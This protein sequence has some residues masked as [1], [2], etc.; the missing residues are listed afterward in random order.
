M[1]IR[2]NYFSRIVNNN[3]YFAGEVRASPP[4]RGYEKATELFIARLPSG[5]SVVGVGSGDGRHLTPFVKGG[6][7]V[8][9]IDPSPD[10]RAIALSRGVPTI[11]GTFENL[12]SLRL[13]PV[14]GI[15]C[16]AALRHIPA[17]YVTR[18][19]RH[20]AELLKSGG[21]VFLTAEL[22]ESSEWIQS[23]P[24]RGDAESLCQ[25]ILESDLARVLTQQGF[26]VLEKWYPS[27][28]TGRSGHWIAVVASKA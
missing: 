28:T 10:R 13:A 22:G 6:F 9:G 14:D 3:G 27:P 7:Q 12:P 4:S 19:L 25:Q 21:V 24:P 23:S 11:E 17:D 1:A 16:G 2:G 20:V 26:L 15:W 18:A 5:G 8:L